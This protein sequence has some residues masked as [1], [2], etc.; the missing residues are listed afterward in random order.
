LIVTA[1]AVASVVITTRNRCSDLHRALES[2]EAQEVPLEVL[3]VDDCSED[4]TADTVAREHPAARLIINDQPRGYI[5]GRNKAAE[6]ATA[7]IIVSIDDDAE[8]SA[9][10]TVT[11]ALQGFDDQRVAAV[12]MP[13][14]NVTS[15]TAS[16][17][18]PPAGGGVW[19]VYTFVGTSHALRRDVFLAIGGYEEHFVHQVEEIDFCERLRA[20]GY[21]VRLV[22]T[23]P[24]RHYESP[25]RNFRRMD[26]YGRRN[27][28]LFAWRCAPLPQLV[29]FVARAVVKGLL[30]GV[31]VRRP[32][33][34]LRGIFAGF[35][36]CEGRAPVSRKL[37]RRSLDLRRNGPQ[38]VSATVEPARSTPD[39]V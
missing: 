34:M 13:F 4:G 7:N 14:V 29:P 36:A 10:D 3:V 32:R 38:D 5:Y 16:T 26:Y 33:N 28:I 24:I 23:P 8:F 19:E 17:G 6:L 39:A 37:W 31:R 22:D 11:Q 12:S 15:D 20:E 1:G 2:C 18:P 27:D 35:R 21:V 30:I 9:P 25:R